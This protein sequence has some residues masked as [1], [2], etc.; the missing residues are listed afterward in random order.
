VTRQAKKRKVEQFEE[1]QV[2]QGMDRVGLS[3]TTKFRISD[4]PERG[5]VDRSFD[6]IL[7]GRNRMIE[8]RVTCHQNSYDNILVPV[9]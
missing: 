5:F 1:E 7:L 6:K 4:I 8:S 3:E 2:N 9:L